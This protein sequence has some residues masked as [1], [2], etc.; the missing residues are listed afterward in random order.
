MLMV[1]R[2][3]YL[4]RGD[5][6]NDKT[7]SSYCDSSRRW[8][9]AYRVNLYVKLISPGQ[10]DYKIRDDTFIYANTISQYKLVSFNDFD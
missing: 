2:L 9:G 3:S 8:F 10:N 4:Y 5:F 6:Y 7:E 1:V